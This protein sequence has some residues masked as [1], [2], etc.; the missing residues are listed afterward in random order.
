MQE[1]CVTCRFALD[2]HGEYLKCRRYA[3]SP[4]EPKPRAGG[5]FTRWPMV[6]LSDWCGEW[7][8]KPRPAR[9]DRDVGA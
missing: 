4:S 3:P 1:M 9:E 2:E 8:P 6:T 7:Q 5:T